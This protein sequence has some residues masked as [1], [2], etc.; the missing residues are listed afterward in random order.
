MTLE[1]MLV[2][3]HATPLLADF[4][5]AHSYQHA[6]GISPPGAS[7]YMAPKQ[8]V[9]GGAS[10]ATNCFYVSIFKPTGTRPFAGQ[11]VAAVLMPSNVVS[12]TR[13]KPGACLIRFA[14]PSLRACKPRPALTPNLQRASLRAFMG[15]RVRQHVNPLG[16][17]YQTPR[18]SAIS[19]PSHLSPSCPIDV[20]LGCA[21]GQFAYQLATRHPERFVVGLDIREKVISANTKRMGGVP[22]LHFAYVNIGVD[23]QR[24]FAPHTV[25]RFHL[26]FPD[27]WW[28]TSHQKRRI[29]DEAFMHVVATQLSRGGEFH[30]ATDVY[31]LALDAM[32]FIEHPTRVH[33]GY[34]N[35]VGPWQFF[36][37]NPFGAASRR[38]DTTLA[39]GQRVWR[40]RYKVGTQAT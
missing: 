19:R 36:R 9:A 15:R 4:G 1:N 20:E 22:N 33:F 27:P 2:H 29:V 3:A 10:A 11:T 26:L 34:H 8:L 23:L 7:T 37:M 28:K 13:T 32:A 14:Q 39:R 12:S 6:V 24:V 16:L 21:D 18:A 31:E 40:L 35:L 5:L 25:S 30:L 38:E 17:K